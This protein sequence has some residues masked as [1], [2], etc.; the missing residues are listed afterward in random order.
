MFA[1]AA[2]FQPHSSYSSVVSFILDAT[3]GNESSQPSKTDCESLEQHQRHVTKKKVSN[4]AFSTEIEG[5]LWIH[6]EDCEI[7][8]SIS[9][10]LLA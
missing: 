2:P 5:E 7:S 9:W 8:F 3:Y 10:S 4:I 6:F 1:L